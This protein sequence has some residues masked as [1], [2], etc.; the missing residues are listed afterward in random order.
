MPKQPNLPGE[1]HWNFSIKRSNKKGLDPNRKHFLWLVLVSSKFYCS[2]VKTRKLLTSDACQ[3][4]NYKTHHFAA[5]ND[6]HQ[7]YHNLQNS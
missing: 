3:C 5:L 6:I 1:E 2:V 4:Q 7:S